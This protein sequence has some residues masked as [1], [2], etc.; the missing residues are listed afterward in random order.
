MTNVPYVKN[1]DTKTKVLLNPITKENPYL[2]KFKTTSL[3]KKEAKFLERTKRLHI[4]EPNPNAKMYIL[5]KNANILPKNKK[6]F[7]ITYKEWIVSRVNKKAK[8]IN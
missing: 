1:Y 3:I 8:S 5:L 4:H 2:H 6:G 7:F